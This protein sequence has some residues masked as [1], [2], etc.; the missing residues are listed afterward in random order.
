MKDAFKEW[1]MTDEGRGANQWPVTS[2]EYLQNRLW[3]A[4]QAGKESVEEKGDEHGG[5]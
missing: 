2:P 1:L 3:W 4:F 5:R